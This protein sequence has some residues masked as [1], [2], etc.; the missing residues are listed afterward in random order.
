MQTDI[1]SSSVVYIMWSATI[2]SQS[3]V[4]AYCLQNTAIV[5]LTALSILR[6]SFCLFELMGINELGIND[7]L[8]TTISLKKR[9]KYVFQ[10]QNSKTLVGFKTVKI[11]THNNCFQIVPLF[12]YFALCSCIYSFF[13]WRMR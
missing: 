1:L 4:M 6:K 13:L 5:T 12:L 10:S 11:N 7:V 3:K 8:M 2:A 9:K